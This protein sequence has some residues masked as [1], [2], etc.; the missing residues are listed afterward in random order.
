MWHSGHST[1]DDPGVDALFPGSGSDGLR[2][3][4]SMEAVTGERG[5]PA[6][7]DVGRVLGPNAEAW[8]SFDTRHISVSDVQILGDSQG[9]R[10]DAGVYWMFTAGGSQE[11]APL[12]PR[13]ARLLGAGAGEL[14]KG[15]RTQPGLAMS[16]NARVWARIETSD[17]PSGTV[18]PVGQSGEWDAH[19]IAGPQVVAAGP[20]D[21]RMYYYSW[22]EGLGRFVIGLARSEDG[23]RWKKTGPIFQGGEGH[24]AAGATAHCVVQD[25]DSRAFFM[26]YEA[27]AA[28]NTRSI[29]L[30]V[31]PDGLGDWQRTPDPILRAGGEGAWD[32]G[33]AYQVLLRGGIKEDRIIVM[34][35]DDVAR[36]PMNPHPNKLFNAPGGP[37]VYQG[38]RVDY[39]GTAVNALNF[40]AVLAGN[41]SGIEISSIANGRVL[42]SG[43]QDHVFV[44]YSD[45]GAPGIVG[46][47][48]GPFL[49]ADQWLSVI[50]SRSGV[51][52]E[53]MVIYLEACESG[54]MFEG[55]LPEDISV[56]AT[57]AANARES[58]VAWL[59]DADEANLSV[60][61]LKEQFQA[62]RLRTSQNFT[63]QQGSHAQRFGQLSMGTQSVAEYLGD[64]E[65]GPAAWGHAGAGA[66]VGEL[67]GREGRPVVDD[68]DC[69]RTIVMS[70]DKMH[71]L[72]DM[73]GAW[74][75]V[76]G[77]LDQYGMR[78]SR[79]FANLCN[80]GVRPAE[81][82]T[83]AALAC[84]DADVA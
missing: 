10:S 63:Y 40:L 43:P 79:A 34:M 7:S 73:V 82:G 30:A 6:T 2:W 61:T 5:A 66:W 49:F 52:Y 54:S 22:D 21:L 19:F 16:P 50:K 1:E 74:E 13:L 37:D 78:H 3:Q 60:E 29:G 59:E 57:T 42:E 14:T 20:N 58:S 26:F 32:E 70:N 23:F 81:L 33:S 84:T 62:V 36:H 48:S 15:W 55:L 75:G 51:G 56:F 72:Q 25:L 46:M 11:E 77:A 12:P 71:P 8:W 4:R 44:Y 69:L 18:L 45:H 80:A 41:R 31:S 39:S 9:G 65:Q 24:D 67:P 28:D 68:W 38:L 47:P 64:A 27:V 35:F 83:A 76:C 53:H 17:E